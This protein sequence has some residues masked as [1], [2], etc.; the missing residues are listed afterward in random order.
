MSGAQ[1]N[2]LMTEL[3]E[4][5]EFLEFEVDDWTA[6]EVA[7]IDDDELWEVSWDDN[8]NGGDAAFSEKLKRELNK[9]ME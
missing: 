5:D 4:E 2:G 3:A 8:D 1:K 7:K 6:K 9:G